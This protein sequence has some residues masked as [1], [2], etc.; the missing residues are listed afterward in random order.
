[1]SKT[2]STAL[3]ADL[4]KDVTT[5]C[6]C[7]KLTRTDGVVLSMTDFDADLVISGVTYSSSTSYTRTAIKSDASLSVDNMDIFGILDSSAITK[8]D[9]ERGVY[10]YAS[11]EVFIV[12]W[13]NVSHGILKFRKGWFG[14]VVVT[15]TG[16]FRTELRGL[17]QAL[18]TETGNTFSPLCR[19]DLGDAKCSIPIKPKARTTSTAYAAGTYVSD[20]N[21]SDDTHI[22]AIYQCTTAGT[23]GTSTLTFN[24]TVGA[25]TTDGSVVW[26]AV[27]PWRG[28]A[29][30]QTV[31]SRVQ[32]T[33]SSMHYR[34]LNNYSSKASVTFSSPDTANPNT[35]NCVISVSNGGSSATI[36]IPNGA[37]PAGA[38]SYF[39]AHV[40]SAGIGVTATVQNTVVV[41]LTKASSTDN[42]AVTRIT[43]DHNNAAVVS[44]A[45]DFMSGGLITWVTG[46]NAGSSIEIK[47]HVQS[48]ETVTLFLRTPFPI[49][50][51]DKFYFQPGCSKGRRA[52]LGKFG[53]IVNFRGEPDAPGADVLFNYPDAN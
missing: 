19:A 23:T 42:G 34:N 20:V 33:S 43:D 4:Q 38:A 9:I 8:A 45:D 21:T 44:F 15:P 17:T 35:S 22:L 41:N 28:V 18:I 40:N 37:N 31:A 16:T 49:Q 36:T 24:T 14:E 6:T 13:A 3:K 47:K 26:T 48:T 39:A 51:G 5:L 2:I 29:T 27:T 53:N 11:V 1:M 32:F 52:C 12:N 7:W 46:A 25:T 30:V 10:D 50:I